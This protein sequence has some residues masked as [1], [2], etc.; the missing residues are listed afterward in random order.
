MS[1]P[2]E[3]LYWLDGGAWAIVD[4][5]THSNDRTRDHYKGFV[6]SYPSSRL[7]SYSIDV[8]G[9]SPCAHTREGCYR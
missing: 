2:Q 3:Y 8:G 1:L 4:M 7:T 5:D 9:A 6:A